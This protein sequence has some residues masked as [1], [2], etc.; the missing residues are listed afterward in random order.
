MATPSLMAGMYGFTSEEKMSD[1]KDYLW[2]HANYQ[3]E[4]VSVT[5]LVRL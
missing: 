4:Q 3:L 5:Q 2:P 1:M